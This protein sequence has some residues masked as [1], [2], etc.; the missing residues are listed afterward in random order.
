[1]IP[2]IGPE[3][4]VVCHTAVLRF[5]NDIVIALI[6][7]RIIAACSQFSVQFSY[8]IYYVK[9]L[10]LW[11]QATD[12]NF[13]ITSLSTMDTL[14]CQLEQIIHEVVIIKAK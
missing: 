5:T 8:D 9:W 13:D 14:A 7:E 3:I 2:A 6:I 11:K 4:F 10:K 12:L 1:M